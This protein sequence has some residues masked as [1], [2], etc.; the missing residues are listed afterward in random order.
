MTELS[1]WMPLD[2]GRDLGWTLIHFLW[3]GALLAALSF[4]VLVPALFCGAGGT[5]TALGVSL[6]EKMIATLSR[7]QLM[8]QV[9]ND[10]FESI[11]ILGSY[12]V[13]AITTSLLLFDY[14]WND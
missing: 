12:G 3:Q 1:S 5:K 13:I 9:W 10:S 7:P 6:S 4:P 14:V 11:S 2:A 8:A